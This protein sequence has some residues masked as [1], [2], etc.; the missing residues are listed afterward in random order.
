MTY[1]FRMTFRIPEG[2]RI[3]HD[4]PVL[5]LRDGPAPR[6]TIQPRAMDQTIKQE[7]RFTLKGEGYQTEGEADED[8]NRWISALALGS[9][10]GLVPVDLEGRKPRGQ[11]SQAFLDQVSLPTGETVELRSDQPG[12][13]VFS[14]DQPTSWLG[15]EGN[16]EAVRNAATTVDAVRR[17]YDE[18]LRPDE[19][20]MLAI[21]LYSAA[22]S[23][24]DADARFLMLMSAVE[25]M[26]VTEKRSDEQVAVLKGLRQEISEMTDLDPEDR[27]QLASAVIGL[28]FESIS[29]AG[30]RLA[31][32]LAPRTYGE[33]S[34]VD[35]FRRAYDVRSNLVHG[36]PGKKRPSI[37]VVRELTGPMIFFVH[38]LILTHGGANWADLLGGTEEPLPAS[39]T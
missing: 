10:A 9:V 2:N 20:T 22:E 23:T 6:V 37:D 34:A 12:L 13:E 15:F 14:E 8:G 36:N 19:R 26:I 27:D 31:E 18:N 32:S 35:F 29:A 21:D 39:D 30:R 33:K 5:I 4:G 38:D 25:A 28:R 11:F 17:A 1:A 3:G 16:A 24:G 7:Q